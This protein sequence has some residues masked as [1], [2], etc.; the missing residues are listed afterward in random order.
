MAQMACG[1]PSTSLSLVLRTLHGHICLHPPP[2]LEREAV[3]FK[4]DSSIFLVAWSALEDWPFIKLP[5]SSFKLLNWP[6][7]SGF[8]VIQLS[9]HSPWATL[10]GSSHRNIAEAPNV[11]QCCHKLVPGSVSF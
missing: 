2:L 8:P 1:R 5:G 7:D 9:D 3:L 4:G 11:K 10:T 6:P